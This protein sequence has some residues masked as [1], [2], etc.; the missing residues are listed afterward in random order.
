[1]WGAGSGMGVRPG[2]LS[3]IFRPSAF[4]LLRPAVQR[5]APRP[6]IPPRFSAV[7]ELLVR[8]RGMPFSGARADAQRIAAQGLT[9]AKKVPGWCNEKSL[10]RGWFPRALNP[11]RRNDL[12]RVPSR[13]VGF[14]RLLERIG[15]IATQSLMAQLL[16]NSQHSSDLY[17]TSAEKRYCPLAVFAQPPFRAPT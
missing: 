11:W 6:A 8:T 2:H 16:A 9:S 4:C 13:I 12:R 1:M 5:S 3:R 7:F 17:V 15:K 10:S 14:G